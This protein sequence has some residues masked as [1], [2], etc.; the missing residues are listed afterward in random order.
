[1]KVIRLL[2]ETDVIRSQS[3]S[4]NI[5]GQLRSN[6]TAITWL[7]AASFDALTN[8]HK[9]HWCFV[10]KWILWICNF[11]NDTP[12]FE[13]CPQKPH[14]FPWIPVNLTSFLGFLGFE[15]TFLTCFS[16]YV[17]PPSSSNS[18]MSDVV[19]PWPFS[20]K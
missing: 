2:N 19:G 3:R 20:S 1:M 13:S 4:M 14:L 15:A 16:T 18:H 17:L 10:F 12:P 9:S 5:F 8:S 11:K 7:M 6:F